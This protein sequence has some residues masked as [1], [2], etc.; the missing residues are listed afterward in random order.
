MVASWEEPGQ[1]DRVDSA[2]RDHNTFAGASRA[3][4]G[5][6]LAFHC[7]A[8]L[9]GD[10][11]GGGDGSATMRATRVCIGRMRVSPNIFPML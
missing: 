3:E 6:L 7:A 9:S 4:L 2:P 5:T 1:D 8:W 10:K 11:L